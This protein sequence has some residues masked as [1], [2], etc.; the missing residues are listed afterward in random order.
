VPAAA[1]TGSQNGNGASTWSPW[2]DISAGY[3]G[4][5]RDTGYAFFGPGY[6]HPISDDTAVVA[7]LNVNYLT[8]EFDN[9]DGTRTHVSGPGFA[10][11]VGLRFGRRDNLKVMVGPDFKRRQREILTAGDLELSE[12]DDTKVGARFAADL[13][14]NFGDHWNLH[15][16]GSYGTAEDWL[17]TRVGIKR[18][19]TNLDWRGPIALSLG[20]EGIVQGNDDIR[21]LQGGALAEIVHARSSLALMLRAGVKNS[22]FENADDESGPYFGIGLYRRF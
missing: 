4:D 6:Y 12:E 7:R 1:Q 21:Q 18:Q 11:T 3:E 20:A 14:N 2:W 16:L 8:Y 22:S 19:L 15:A 9:G 17:W 13:Y 10:P 5:S